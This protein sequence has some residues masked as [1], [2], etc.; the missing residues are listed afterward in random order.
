MRDL[1]AG[2]RKSETEE[3]VASYKTAWEVIIPFLYKPEE[4]FINSF[5]NASFL[6]ALGSYSHRR[7]SH[8]IPFFKCK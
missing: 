1:P 7:E 3:S 2:N 4:D 6:V 8:F 5:V